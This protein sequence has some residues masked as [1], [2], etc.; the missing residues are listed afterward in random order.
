MHSL[1]QPQLIGSKEVLQRGQA[2]QSQSQGSFLERRGKCEILEPNA[3]S[4]VLL[5][6]NEAREDFRAAGL[7]AGAT[8]EAELICIW[9][10]RNFNF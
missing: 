4:S 10:G 6:N 8:G 2:N 1:P 3:F 5:V 9:I 7:H